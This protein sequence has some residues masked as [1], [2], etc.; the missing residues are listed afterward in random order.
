MAFAQVSFYKGVE[1]RFQSQV[2]LKLQENKN[3]SFLFLSPLP[4]ILFGQP[5]AVSVLSQLKQID[6]QVFLFR[7][8]FVCFYIYCFFSYR[9]INRAR[10]NNWV[11]PIQPYLLDFPQ[12]LDFFFFFFSSKSPFSSKYIY[13]SILSLSLKNTSTYIPSPLK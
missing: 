13:R 8:F 2:V 12:C 9:E 10:L 11:S 6:A 4:R 3:N 7:F 1:M 5:T